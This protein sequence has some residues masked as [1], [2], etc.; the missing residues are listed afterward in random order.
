MEADRTPDELNDR[1]GVH[2]EFQAAAKDFDLDLPSGFSF[3]D[4]DPSHMNAEAGEAFEPG[5][6][7]ID[8][9]FWW[10]ASMVSA[11]VTAHLSG[12]DSDAR[13]Y[14]EALIEGTTT[15]VYRTY[16]LDEPGR[17]WAD[18]VGRPALEQ[19]DWSG[20]ISQAASGTHMVGFQDMARNAGHVLANSNEQ[21]PI[22]PMAST[23]PISGSTLLNGQWTHGTVWRGHAATGP[24]WLRPTWQ[25]DG[26]TGT[27]IAD[28]LILDSYLRREG[29][30][31]AW[32]YPNLTWTWGM[33]NTALYYK[34]DGSTMIYGN[35][36]SGGYIRYAVSTRWRGFNLSQGSWS[37]SGQIFI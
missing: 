34:R 20:L 1:N 19:D 26:G 7:S 4:R 9:Y 5:V 6:G 21:G 18:I 32:T 28:H 12:R 16:V 29:F 22:S 17:G 13:R 8:A 11:A 23:Q 35:S 27:V 24:I 3:P 25:L 15:E 10:E 14:V 30:S 37:W 2:T 31:G 36:S 33:R